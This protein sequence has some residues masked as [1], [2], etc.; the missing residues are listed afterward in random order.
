MTLRD[1]RIVRKRSQ[2]S[3]HL[4]TFL[5]IVPH[6]AFDG[7]GSSHEPIPSPPELLLDDESSDENIN[8]P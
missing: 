1:T 3:I 2:G 4:E 6:I 5:Y 7:A 8:R